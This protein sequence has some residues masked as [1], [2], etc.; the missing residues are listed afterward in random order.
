MGQ[1]ESDRYSNVGFKFG[2][3]ERAARIQYTPETCWAAAMSSASVLLGVAEKDNQLTWY[4]MARR[5]GFLGE[6]T[7]RIQPDALKKFLDG[8]PSF[9]VDACTTIAALAAALGPALRDDKIVL[10]FSAGHVVLLGQMQLEKGANA[11]G[12]SYHVVDPAVGARSWS[13]ADL[14][15]FT[16][17]D[18]MIVART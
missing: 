18:G 7:T 13:Q 6:G 12:H 4:T 10:M 11:V 14:N 17:I 16:L 15:A 2:D 5:Y 9:K 3:L 1:W 8:L